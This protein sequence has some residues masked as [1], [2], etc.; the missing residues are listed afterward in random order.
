MTWILDLIKVLAGLIGFRRSERREERRDFDIVTEKWE[1][2]TERIESERASVQ[3]ELDAVRRQLI[4]VE[5]R[6]REC[7][8]DR[9][10]LLTKT[11]ALEAQLD[12]F[13]LECFEQ[14]RIVASPKP[15][16]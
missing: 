3:K 16:A 4:D 15:K 11:A 10:I 13:K 1:Q 12:Q 7:E 6:L 8:V 14:S 2:L 5:R 9:S